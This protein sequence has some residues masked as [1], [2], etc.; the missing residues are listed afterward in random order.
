MTENPIPALRKRLESGHP[1]AGEIAD[2][3]EIHQRLEAQLRHEPEDELD[4]IHRRIAEHDLEQ[5]EQVFREWLRVIERREQFAQEAG[6]KQLEVADFGAVGDGRAD[7]GPALRKAIDALRCAGRGSVLH[8]PKGH[9]RVAE[10]EDPRRRYALVLRGLRDVTIEA[11]PGTRLVAEPVG[12]VLLLIDCENVTVRGLDLGHDP[13][14]CTQGV[15][16]NASSEGDE[17]P[18][19]VDWQLDAGHSAP[20]AEPFTLLEQLG[21]GLYDAESA[22]PIFSHKGLRLTAVKRLEEAGLYRLRCEVEDSALRS[23][24]V[25][26]TRLGIRSR[27]LPGGRCALWVE[28]SRFCLFEKFEIRDSYHFAVMATHTTGCV[29][30]QIEIG[31]TVEADGALRLCSVNADGF[32]AKSN[33]HGPRIESCKVL[34]TPDDCANLY[35]RCASVAAQLDSTTIVLDSVWDDD[36]RWSGDFADSEKA[37]G[38]WGWRPDRRAYRPGDLLMLIDPTTGRADS[39]ARVSAIQPY[40]WHG[41]QVLALRLDQPLPSGLRTRK[42]LGLDYPVPASSY[43][44]NLQKEHPELPIEHF[45]INL[46]TKS[47]GFVM[48]DNYLGRNTVAGVKMKASNGLIVGNHFERHGWCSI[49][50]LMELKWQ[51]GFAPHNLLIRGNVFDNRF[52]VYSACGYPVPQTAELRPPWIHH[53]DLVDN[54]FNPG[55]EGWAVQT[56]D[57]RRC[58][59]ESVSEV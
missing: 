35:C 13:H 17:A 42:D 53:I 1:L 10:L 28:D 45:A 44:L 51:E 9:Y 59:F 14:P 47:D 39:L 7:D 43:F 49:S 58:N 18:V 25:P 20:D 24:L 15:V 23:G 11:E 57:A 34:N 5:L 19:D 56:N 26:G 55:P 52:G 33:R 37:S 41:R 31:G 46:S 21:V 50:L 22:E 8:L 27:N 48:R 16:V 36:D 32:H 6:A 3:L 29:F 12:G 38:K 40:T 54:Q 2:Q 30:R 4:R